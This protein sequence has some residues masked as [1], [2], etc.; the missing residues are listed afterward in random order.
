ML[1]SKEINSEVLWFV[2]V[3]TILALPFLIYFKSDFA[4]LVAVALVLD[5]LIGFV[6]NFYRYPL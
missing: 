5:L 1:L 2:E 3:G 4:L 6:F